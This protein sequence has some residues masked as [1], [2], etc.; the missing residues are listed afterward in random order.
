MIF[1]ISLIICIFLHEFGHLIVAKFC[2][3]KVLVYSIGFGKPI[4]WSK[5]IGDTIYQITPWIFGGYCALKDELNYSRSKYAFTN[6]PYRCKFA[7]A[8]AGVTVNIISGLIVG[9]IGILINNYPL[10]Y[11]GTVSV[12]LGISNTLPIPC[13]DGSYIYL[14]WLEKIYGKR[15]GYAIMNKICT[16]FLRILMILNILSIPYVIY[17][18]LKGRIM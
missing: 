13:L 12:M 10:V 6:L 18:F 11:F 5:K 3:C 16:K 7:I 9:G 14:V 2:K 8:I 1:F 4:L 15:K 17:L